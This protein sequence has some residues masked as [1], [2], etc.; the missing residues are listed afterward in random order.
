MLRRRRSSER[1]QTL[2]LAIAFLAMFGLLGAAV[3]S[4]ASG[5]QKQRVS[6]EAT[7]ASNS[8]ADGS[9]QFA[10]AD[11]GVQ[12][13]G[14]VISGTMK[15]ASGDTLSYGP[16]A[17]G[18][19]NSSTSTA[20]GENC[21]LCVLNY[22]NC[23]PGATPA[24]CTGTPIS[25]HKGDWTD[26]GEIDV[27]GSIS[28]DSICSGTCPPNNGRIGLYGSGASCGSTCSPGNVV[29]SNQVLD[30]LA[31]ALPIPTPAANPPSESGGT[32]CP[33]TYK[34][35]SGTLVLDPWGSGSC[36]AKS[37]PS[38]YIITGSFGGAGNDT[39]TVN[40][41]TLYFTPSASV[42]FAG[43]GTVGIDCGGP[44]VPTPCA[45]TAPATGPYAGVS[46][47]F[48]PGYT[49]TI[50]Y[51]G[52]GDFVESG[53]FEASHAT[54]SMGGNGGSQSF[55]TGR[56]IISQIQ[57]NGNGGAGLGFGGTTISASGC[58]Y[59][60]DPLTGKLAGGSSFAAH[61]R[62]ET[63]CNSGSPSSIIGFAY[64]SGP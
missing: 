12:G 9:A 33:G 54:L 52:N 62:F 53:T 15:F 18:A 1:G 27:N 44:P 22:A 30:P 17:A 25:V 47:F 49:G 26:P 64:G 6:T 31:G 7:A 59:W 45:S 58:N 36:A 57:G 60:N 35:L 55:Q 24:Q 50:S 46:V 41:S 51:Q 23:P 29:L 21:G 63:A 14:T 2:I 8:V 20:P 56:L 34:N 39:I 5:V 28:V 37:A 10:I 19:C 48:D 42:S 32:L 61:V 40:G 4:F 43:N 13:C 11:T 3:L 16:N 38:L